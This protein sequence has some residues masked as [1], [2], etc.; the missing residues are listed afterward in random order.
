[1][2][3]F[4]PLAAAVSLFAGTA[5][6]AGPNLVVNGSFEDTVVGS[7]SW[8]NVPSINGWTVTAGP[9]TGFELRNNAVGTAFH[10]ANFVE[11]DTTGN[12]TITQSFDSLMTGG[13]YAL[14]F[15]YT[16]RINQP[17]ATNGIEVLWNGTLL[18]ST[19]S[20]AGGATHVWTQHQ[21]QVTALAGLNTL[22]FR[23]VGSS[24]TLGG[25]LDA[26][27]LTSAVPEP[28]SYA[29]MLAGL[30]G[31]VAMKRRKPR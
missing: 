30:V 26:V 19:I 3:S 31:V 10:G 15:A 27:S 29:L 25:S 24:D 20:A 28:G 18:G 23:S 1:M 14:S 6:A 8:V 22:S 17:S 9:G 7:G 12:S 13:S 21:F 11:L 2:R 4:I 16:P 5:Q